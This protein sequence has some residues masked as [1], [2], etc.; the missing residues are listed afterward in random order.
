MTSVAEPLVER[1]DVRT[2]LGGGVILGVLTALGVAVFSWVSRALDGTSEVA[3]QS[4][5]VLLGTVLASYVPAHWVRPR[6]VDGIAWAALI[7]LIGS[8]VFTVVDTA[9]LR[10][11]GAYHRT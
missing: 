8:L 10:P 5:V 7:G 4:A 11:I 9:V 3:V 6:Q 2:I 1:A